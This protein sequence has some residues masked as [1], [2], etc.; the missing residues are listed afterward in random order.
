MAISQHDIDAWFKYH[1]FNEDQITASNDVRLA[2]K[3]LAETIN[4][5]VPDSADKTASIR[6]IREAVWTANA[7]I[8]VNWPK[9]RPTI[10]ELEAILKS[11]EQP[12]ITVNSDG[13]I[14]AET[15]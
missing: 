15:V 10:A 6:K 8:A 4:K 5:H 9:Q 7:A 2:G 1:T 11:D 3:I 13:S 12:T 14:S